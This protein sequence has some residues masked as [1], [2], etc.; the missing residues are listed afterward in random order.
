MSSTPSCHMTAKDFATIE[1]FLQRGAVR[2]EALLRLLRRKLSTAIVMFHDDIDAQVATIG[3]I[4]DYTVDGRLRERS[5]LSHEEEGRRNEADEEQDGAA[6]LPVTTLRGLALL[7]LRSGETIAVQHADG[8]QEEIRLDRVAFQPE[9]ALKRRAAE[10]R[11]EGGTIVSLAGRHR[12][13]AADPNDDDP[14]P[15]AA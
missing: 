3:S 6:A 5:T 8:R 7:G 14:G 1:T 11:G 9:A 13:A 2:D 15:R 10:R 12:P 4:V